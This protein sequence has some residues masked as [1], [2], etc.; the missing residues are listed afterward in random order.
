MSLKKLVSVII[1]AF[2]AA[3][4][5][6]TTLASVVAQTYEHWETIVINDGSTDGTLAIAERFSRQ[7]S[8]IQVI[9]TPNQGLSASR[10]FILVNAALTRRGEVVVIGDEASDGGEF[11][12]G[13]CRKKPALWHKDFE[14]LIL[15]RR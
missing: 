7:D 3:S 13:S 12:S 9:S 8:R 10:N 15:L 4:S 6:E 14:N 2:N 11:C 1:P 5:L